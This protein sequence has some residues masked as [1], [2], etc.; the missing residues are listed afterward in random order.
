MQT[1]ANTIGTV[2]LNRKHVPSFGTMRAVLLVSVIICTFFVVL[3]ILVAA[4]LFFYPQNLERITF[5]NVNTNQD[6][7]SSVFR[8][9]P[10]KSLQ[11]F[12]KLA[13]KVTPALKDKASTNYANFTAKAEA[14][15]LNFTEMAVTL[16]YNCM[17]YELLTRDG[18]LLKIFRVQASTHRT[19]TP[20]LLVHG[21]LD[22]ADTFILRGS[23]S[24]LGLLE[25]AGKDVWI[26][27]FRGNKYSRKHA[28]LNP[29]SD[30]V[31][32]DFTFHE[33]GVYDLTAIIDLVLEVT[34]RNRLQAVA[35]SLGSTAF[36]AMTSTRPEYN[37]KVELLVAMAP[38]CHL[39]NLKPPFSNIFAETVLNLLLNSLD[40]NEIFGDYL[41]FSNTMKKLCTFG[42][43]DRDT[44]LQGGY[45]GV[46]GRYS[47]EVKPDFVPLLSNHYPAG[48]SV[49]N[50]NHL[51]QL[52]LMKS[53]SHYDYG[54]FRNLFMY[55]AFRPPPYDMSEIR[56][57]VA[58]FVARNDKLSTWKDVQMLK[59]ELVNVVEHRVVHRR[60][61]NHIDYV[62][63][64]NVHKYLYPQVIEI[65]QKYNG[66][67]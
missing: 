23:K 27:N 28:V 26:S 29:D 44:C 54:F 30:S 24:L 21:F 59:R 63:G 48:T 40:E 2:V 33:Q 9:N 61:F 55:T 39:D 17:E 11:K 22:S 43:I 64:E 62:W 6:Y 57:K 7:N 42:F 41:K 15:T 18:Y 52:Y 49:K 56:M 31:F 50:L 53:F 66:K 10:L 37:E 36:F 51:T 19:T 65:L 4:A 12:M 35:H 14:L 32:W 34:G 20:V 45:Y 13:V 25:N 16:G 60:R 38:I 1:R 47:E 3:I 58:M 5:D 46:F 67:M 8:F